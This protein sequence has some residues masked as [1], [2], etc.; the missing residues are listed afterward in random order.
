MRR[1]KFAILTLFL[2]SSAALCAQDIYRT[3]CNG[4]ISRLDSLL[5]TTDVNLKN[6]TNTTPLMIAA[7][8]RQKEAFD[9]LIERGADVNGINNFGILP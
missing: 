3:T 9:L 5:Q 6:R 8:C 1:S 4:N 7:L 2:L